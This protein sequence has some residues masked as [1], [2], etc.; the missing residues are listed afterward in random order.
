MSE[1]KQAMPAVPLTLEG[2]AVLHQMYRLRW[3]EWRTRAAI[4]RDYAAKEF[5][6]AMAALE[7]S[8]SSAM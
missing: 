7:K 2:A 4:E 5:A 3:P 6:D 8:N 1:N